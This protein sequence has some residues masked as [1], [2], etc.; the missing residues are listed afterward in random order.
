MFIALLISCLYIFCIF[1]PLSAL[2]LFALNN[3]V[4]ASCFSRKLSTTSI[5]S[6]TSLTEKDNFTL[7][8]TNSIRNILGSSL[9]SNSDRRKVVELKN[10]IISLAKPTN[11]GLEATDETRENIIRLTKKLQTLNTV[12]RLTSSELMNGSWKLLFTTNKGS[13]AGKLVSI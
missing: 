6:S 10:Q 9:R 1:V 11:N 2:N 5:M 4:R 7:K 3:Y 8:F 12:K 13:S